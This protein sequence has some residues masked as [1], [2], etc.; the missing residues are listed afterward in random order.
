MTATNIWLEHH[1]K[2]A[3][4]ILQMLCKMQVSQ[5]LKW[6]ARNRE[7][8]FQAREKKDSA[9]GMK[10]LRAHSWIYRAKTAVA[11]QPKLQDMLPFI[12]K[13]SAVVTVA[14]THFW[15]CCLTTHSALHKLALLCIIGINIVLWQFI[16]HSNS[17]VNDGVRMVP[18]QDL[19]NGLCFSGV[20]LS[21]E[22]FEDYYWIIFQAFTNPCVI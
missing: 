17:F 9:S 21:R 13:N 1:H 3:R 20:T 10:C 2:L 8:K 4:L 6:T 14:C 22:S 16:I 12:I 11:M 19:C 5:N 7:G 18:S 15:R